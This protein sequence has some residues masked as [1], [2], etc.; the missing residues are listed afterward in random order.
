MRRSVLLAVIVAM[1]LVAACGAPD[2][3]P[4]GDETDASP[5]VVASPTATDVPPT[6]E[7]RATDPG[8]QG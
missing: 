1:P 3:G 5:E 8:W 6:V 7:P 2:A 4:V